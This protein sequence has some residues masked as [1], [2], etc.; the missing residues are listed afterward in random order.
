MAGH[1]RA[2]ATHTPG[3]DL[4]VIARGGGAR[5]ELDWAD[6]EPVVRAIAT[7]PIPVWTA[8][9]HA[10][11]ST[12]ADQVAHRSCVTPTAA[13]TAIVEVLRDHH[14]DRELAGPQ[15]TAEQ[16]HRRFDLAS[17]DALALVLVVAAVLLALALL[18]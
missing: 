11:D 3:P 8:L 1:I 9:G 16:P 7:S 6:A 13:A 2:L 12:I 5:S 10:T 15:P 4:I 18:V 14:H 17:V